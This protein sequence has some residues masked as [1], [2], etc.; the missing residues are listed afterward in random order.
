VSAVPRPLGDAPDLAERRMRWNCRRG[1][2][3]L[4]LVLRRFMDTRYAGLSS[5]ERERFGELLG[6]PDNDLWDMVAGR[7]QPADPR[8]LGVLGMLRAC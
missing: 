4:D 7:L 8:V 6:Y 2:L 5:A 3:E 1:L